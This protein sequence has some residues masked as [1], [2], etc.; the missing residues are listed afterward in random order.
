MASILRIK[1]SEVSGN[2]ATLGAGELAYSALPD[3]GANGGDRLYIGMGV[4][5][6][7]NAVNH[8]IIGGKRYTDM[9]DAATNINTVSTLVKRDSSGNFSA[10][11]ITAN[12]T[13][14]VT[15]DVTGNIT[16][17]GT[18]TFTTID[19]NGGTIDGTSIG[20][21]TASTMTGTTITA[22]SGFSGNLTGNVTG[23]VTGDLTGNVT[24][25]ITSTGTSTFT[26]IDVNGGTIDATV[27]GGTVAAAIIGTTITAST[28]FSGNLTGNVTG[29][30]TGNIT[31]TGTSTFSNI[32]VNGGTV[33][34]AIIGGTSAAA[35]TGT[36]I[37]AN[38]GFSGNV[39]GNVTGNL[40]G[41]VTGNITSSGT[42]TFTTIDVNGGTIDGAVIGGTVAAAI[43][44]TTITASTGFSGN[45][46][47]NVTG[48]LTG[49]AS[50]AT[51]WQS[52]RNLTISG[53]ATGTFTGVNGSANVDAPL[54]LANTGV[55][56]GSYGSTTEIP[57]FTVD[58]KGRLTAAGT[59]TIS[60]TLNITDGTNNDAVALGTD[61][62][63]F[64]AGTGI[65]TTVSNNQVSIAIGQAVGTTD[66][67][68]FNNVTVSG[69]LSSDDITAAN[70]SVAGNATI[71]G[72]LT[73]QG[74]TTTV[75]SITVAIGDKNITLAKDATNGGEAD[76]AG[77]TILGPTTPATILYNNTNSSWDFN[78]QVYANVTGNLTGNADTATK[79]AT[80][81]DLTLSGDATGTLTAVDGTATVDA[82]VTL[83]TVNSNVGTFGNST[84]VPTLTVNEKG[85]IT[86]LSSTSI[87]LATAA[88]TSGLAI[89]GLASFNTAN[90]S[91]TSGYVAITEVD[92][93]TY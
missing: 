39:T 10:G 8:I 52:A 12:L 69:Q 30:V 86:A 3:S 32:D 77:L 89:N 38:T 47:G 57:T 23:N 79:W 91:V 19:V 85:L 46:T 53:D 1:R 40:T 11:T 88:S 68:T 37:T 51:T 61:T 59:S 25:N 58:S 64:N 70:I 31:S 76:G 90:F 22:T 20:S 66:N 14:N 41:N 2:P 82:V 60:T 78:K 16:S 54:T 7:G 87:P 24:G 9:I 34:G 36:T 42:S 93:G 63:T 5:T 6:S 17:S 21:T 15:G 44:G 65:T 62:L 29:D 71:T 50:T 55:V 33:D 43:T 67:V 92:G 84:S 27:I 72:D 83:A 18:S 49:N 13:G 26:T 28:G 56:A 80:A 74:T 35:I 48:D 4:E 45:L 73:V 75:N 81:R